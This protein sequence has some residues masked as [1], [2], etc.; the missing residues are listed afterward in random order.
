MP[1]SFQPSAP[2]LVRCFQLRI[3]T[4]TV[5]QFVVAPPHRRAALLL[6]LLPVSHSHPLASS[7]PASFVPLVCARDS[8]ARTTLTAAHAARWPGA[9][10]RPRVGG[11]RVC[12]SCSVRG[13]DDRTASCEL[14]VPS[15]SAAFAVDVTG[16]RV[17]ST[18][19][20]FGATEQQRSRSWLL[21]VPIAWVRRLV[22]H[23]LGLIVAERHLGT[24]PF[25]S[26]HA[27]S[28]LP[29][30]ILL[31]FAQVHWGFGRRVPVFARLPG[32]GGHPGLR[33]RVHLGGGLRRSQGKKYSNRTLPFGGVASPLT[34]N[35]AS[36]PIFCF[37]PYF[38]GLGI[39][40]EQSFASP[41]HFSVSYS[42]AQLVVVGSDGGSGRNAPTHSIKPDLDG[43]PRLR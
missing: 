23:P 32:E 7:R 5:R 37:P 20:A 9:A 22:S 25:S 27:S 16:H 30:F 18:A 12:V 29:P 42:I 8:N 21:L 19:C 3:V 13:G 24:C 11:G 15:I 4:Y 40:P 14:V 6:V 36:M 33:V 2:L 31:I 28:R 10:R 17:I 26:F 43:S 39:R 38:P 34:S 35:S 41:S 1:L